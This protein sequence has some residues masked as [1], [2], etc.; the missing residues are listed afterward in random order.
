MYVPYMKRNKKKIQGKLI[1]QSTQS[2]YESKM[3]VEV[4]SYELGDNEKL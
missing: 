4:C 3:Q 1:T 2:M